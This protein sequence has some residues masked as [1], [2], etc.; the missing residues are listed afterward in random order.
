MPTPN[1]PPLAFSLAEAEQASDEWGLNCGPSAIAAVLGL[2]LDCIRPHLGDFESKRYTNPTLMGSILRSLNAKVTRYATDKTWP[3][4]G[5]ARI[6]WEG[7]WTKDGVPMRARYR[8]THWVGVCKIHDEYI[9]IWDVNALS[10]GNGTGWVS[11]ENWIDILVP[12]LTSQYPRANGKWHITHAVE[13][14]R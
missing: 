4:Y 6:Q 10:E 5:L 12:F 14:E 9:G 3:K 1:P 13:I 2:S 8:Y 11:R 7:P